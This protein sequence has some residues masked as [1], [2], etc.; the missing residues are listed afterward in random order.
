MRADPPLTAEHDPGLFVT[1]GHEYQAQGSSAEAMAAFTAAVAAAPQF[2]Q[3]PKHRK[4]IAA[5]ER[6]AGA[7]TS[8][9]PE[10]SVWRRFRWLLP[11]LGATSLVAIA[12]AA[13]FYI[14]EHRTLHIV[15]GFGAPLVLRLEDGRE[16]QAP[17]RAQATVPIAEGSHVVQVAC[18]DRGLGSEPFE[19]SSGYWE[20]FFRKPLYV[21][22]PGGGAALLWEKVTYSA[23]PNAGAGED[24]LYVGAVFFAFDDID[25]PFEQFPRT[26]QIKRG[27]TLTKTRV[28]LLPIAP[29]KLLAAPEHLL[30]G[31][32][33]L[34]LAEAHLRLAPND[35]ELR[36]V[37]KATSA[38]YG[39]D[40]RAR[41]FLASLAPIREAF[42]QA[43]K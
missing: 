11:A 27:Q 1:L 3:D 19:I 16:I 8:V 4:A 41:Q 24:R 26:V 22:N 40:E 15:N 29:M 32:E 20:R 14:A 21:L 39:A 5:A 6:A 30:S 33:R 17:A 7:T 9:L 42:P 36:D 12:A 43:T 31:D 25:C 23:A 38:K 13:N 10:L 34:S 35:A 2:A 18:G 28:S 37:Y